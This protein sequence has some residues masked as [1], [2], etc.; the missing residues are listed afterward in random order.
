M[1]LYNQKGEGAILTCYELMKQW[2]FSE[3]KLPSSKYSQ[4]DSF[5]YFILLLFFIPPSLFPK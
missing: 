5:I 3:A 4:T 2:C 1:Q